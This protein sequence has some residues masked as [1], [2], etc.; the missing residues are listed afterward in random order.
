MQAPL[1][2]DLKPYTKPYPFIQW[3]G[4]KRWLATHIIPIIKELKPE[5]Y[6]ESFIGGGAMLWEV[7]SL[8]NPPKNILINDKCT[9]LINLYQTIKSQPEEL[10][11]AIQAI[12]NEYS[13][14]TNHHARKVYFY[15]KKDK[16]NSECLSE[17]ERGASLIFLIR[18]GF[19]GLYRENKLGKINN[20]Y[21][22]EDRFT[23]LNVENIRACSRALQN[24]YIMNL[25][26]SE[27]PILP[28]SFY[29]I[30]PPYFPTSPNYHHYLADGF[31]LPDQIRLRDWADKI[32]SAGGRFTA[33]NSYCA[34]TYAL[35]HGYKID[36][37]MAPQSVGNRKGEPATLTPEVLISN[38]R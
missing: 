8:P 21:G 13:S 25:D 32:A 38:I 37:I 20:S 24:V 22:Y 17:P 6:I 29:Y 15:Q 1:L 2:F 11:S 19:K 10:I 33:S 27:L 7:T 23:H 12:K 36:K 35:W 3:V 28:N 4:G 16:F 9:P 14:L 26:F 34:Q 18:A 30:D 31:H 5:N